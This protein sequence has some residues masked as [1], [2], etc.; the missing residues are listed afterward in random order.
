MV[1]LPQ[2]CL[3]SSLSILSSCTKFIALFKEF[4]GFLPI[5]NDRE[6]DINFHTFKMAGACKLALEV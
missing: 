6:R 1:N 5:I 4:P 2:W 3:Y